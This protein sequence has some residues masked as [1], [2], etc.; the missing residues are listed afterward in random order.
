MISEQQKQ[1]EKEKT[2]TDQEGQP[3]SGEESMTGLM[4]IRNNSHKLYTHLTIRICKLGDYTK[5]YFPFREPGREGQK[6]Q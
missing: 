2:V 1:K 6:L 4:C 5:A 3:D